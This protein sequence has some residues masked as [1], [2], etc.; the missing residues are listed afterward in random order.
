MKNT[1]IALIILISTISVVASYFIGNAILGDP[2]DRVE[3]V[4]YMAPISGDVDQ[5]DSDTYNAYALN[6]TV[7]V[8]VGNCGPLEQW[9]EAKRAC[10]PKDGFED[11]EENKTEESGKVENAEN[12]ENTG[13]VGNTDESGSSGTNGSSTAGGN[14]ADTSTSGDE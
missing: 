12:T 4:S 11:K 8:Y 5:P 10:V 7:E 9:S 13:N 6:P 2:N 14:P 3:S 1:D